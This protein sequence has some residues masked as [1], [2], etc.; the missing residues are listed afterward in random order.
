MLLCGEE[1]W[2]GV[3]GRALDLPYHYYLPLRFILQPEF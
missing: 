2:G 3:L 1:C